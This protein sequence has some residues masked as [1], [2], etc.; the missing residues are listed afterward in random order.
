MSGTKNT[1]QTRPTQD[2]ATAREIARELKK[3]HKTGE[4]RCIACCPA[5]DD[6]TL[7]IDLDRDFLRL[8]E[9]ARFA[10]LA[11]SYW[12]SASLAADQGDVHLLTLHCKQVATASKSVV[13]LVNEVEANPETCRRAA[14]LNSAFD[15][16]HEGE[17]CGKKSARGHKRQSLLLIKPSQVP[18]WLNADSRGRIRTGVRFYAAQSSPAI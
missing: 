16:T 17:N 1:R 10:D 13:V 15:V 9:L 14:A 18:V 6:R 3:G 7:S 12:R 4:S 2:Y 8:D 11:A 5:H